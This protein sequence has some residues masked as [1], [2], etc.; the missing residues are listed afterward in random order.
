MK[1]RPTQEIF[2]PPTVEEVRA[3][4]RENVFNIDSEAF[5]NFYQSDGWIVGKSKLANW[6]AFVCNWVMIQKNLSK[7][8]DAPEIRRVP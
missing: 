2:I 7:R 3:Y 8:P 5:E 6:R 4:C 1:N